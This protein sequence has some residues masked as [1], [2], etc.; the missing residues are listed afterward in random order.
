MGVLDLFRGRARSASLAA[1]PPAPPASPLATRDSSLLTRATHVDLGS[2]DEK[3]RTLP[4]I[5]A[6]EGRV[7]VYDYRGG[8]VI[9]EVLAADGG[10]F[11]E[12]MPLLDS[13]SRW[14]SSSVLGS[15]RDIRVDG[16]KLRGIVHFGRDLGANVDSIWERVRQGHLTDGSIGY[17]YE[18]GDFTDIRPGKSE[19]INGRQWTAGKRTLRVVGRWRMREYSV[20]PVGADE[21]AKLNRTDN[22]GSLDVG[23]EESPGSNQG[24]SHAAGRTSSHSNPQHTP[25]EPK[26]M[27]PALRRFLVALG[28]RSDASDD[29]AMTF[30][31]TLG[32]D[33]AARAARIESGAEEFAEGA[34]VFEPAAAGTQTPAAGNQAR[35]D[36][37]TLGASAPAAGRWVGGRSGVTSDHSGNGGNAG[38]A[39][40]E[41]AAQRAVAAERERIA[42]AESFRGQVPDEIVQRARDEGWNQDR[43]QSDFLEHFRSG[44]SAPVS[45]NLG[46]HDATA[47][48]T[49]SQRAIQA[50]VLMRSGFDLDSDLLGAPEMRHVLHDNQS[51]ARWLADAQAAHRAGGRVDDESSRALEA[52]YQLRNMSIRDVCVET[53]NLS[54]ARFDR[55]DIHEVW[56]YAVSSAAVGEIFTTNFAVQ[57]MM[58]FMG[59]PDTT[60]GW[61]RESDLP[62]LQTVERK[63]MGKASPLK[64]RVAGQTAE[65]VTI[66][67]IG[68]SYKLAEYAGQFFLD[69]QD[70]INDRFGAMDVMPD[71]MGE[72]AMELRPDLVFAI[73]LSN[74]NMGRD[75]TPIFH[76]DH[77]NLHTS[78]PLNSENLAD[79]KSA[80]STQKKGDRLIGVTPRGLIVP[81]SKEDIAWELVNSPEKRDN[82]DGKI[83]GTRNWAQGRF[84]VVPEPRLDV[85]VLD[86]DSGTFVAGKP[87]SQFLTAEVG[88][89]G[90]E[91]G[92][93]QGTGRRP[94][95]R[96]FT[97]TE[98]RFGFG[99]DVQHFAGAKA[100]GY[101]GLSEMRD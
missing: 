19:V 48:R 21:E 78:S 20:L 4:A 35:S 26:T 100:T 84:N 97:A 72:A 92:F 57:F 45:G 80:M 51:N 33:M 32:G 12:R 3:A 65:H 11:P 94:T 50:A 2:I 42:F 7:L 89:Y 93:L 83:Y 77:G 29:Q 30:Y 18:E 36:N 101:E 69:I 47:G 34:R 95:I 14:S 41:V 24:V 62:N 82:T 70:A 76:A 38:A 28:L 71:E 59:K 49:V 87:G 86:P 8:Q 75:S 22:L 37:G 63:Q 88:R 6:T 16:D 9:E 61:T 60:R 55:Y 85:G 46:I 64:K 54:G 27:P 58:G 53:L 74:P 90:I 68:E 13:H 23:G 98:G 39:N 25:F 5:L 56:R 66:D 15:V 44:R 91:V 73:L 67:A 99:W 31:R 1:A 81:D 79:A 10:T 96:R 43:I 40:A 17:R 52:A